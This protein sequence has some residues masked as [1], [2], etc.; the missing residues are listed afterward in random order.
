MVS[1]ASYDFRSD[2]VT[3]P[4]P[5][6]LQAIVEAPLGDDVFGDDP[7]VQRLEAEAAEM[8][9]K[10]AAVFVTSGTFSNHLALRTHVGPLQEVLCDHR[11]HIH[12]WEAG[13]IHANGAAVA[14]VVPSAEGGGFLTAAD[15]RSHARLDNCLYHQPVTRL[16]ALENT[17]NGAVMPLA[18]LVGAADEA[19][20]LGLATH[21]D[22]A[23][24][25]NACAASGVSAADYAAPF[26]T[27]SICLSKGLGA[28]VG[29][30]LVGGAEQ[31]DRAR[32]HRKLLGGG[33][34]QAG[35]LAAAG[36]H[37]L[38]HHRERMAEDHEAAAEL[39]HGLSG[40]GFAV[41]PPETNMVWT[42]PPDDL[43]GLGSF[44][45]LTKRLERDDGI[46]VGGAYG[47]PP[48]RQPW[49]DAAK[50]VRFVTHLQTPRPAVRALLTGMARLLRR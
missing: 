24:L 39:A 40:L 45:E 23:R 29:S 27:V 31:I 48:G 10:E 43:A 28:P 47:G 35:L 18:Q 38:A 17:L 1:S 3:R 50:S 34:R 9:G 16:F 22:G 33:W 42:A 2:T 20:S 32:H 8:L 11:A 26:D 19:R 25:F 14:P 44:E 6:M 41:Q 15:V 5:A 12:V 30:V 36:R 37:A 21:L 46:L 7:S 49:G 4:T 13:G